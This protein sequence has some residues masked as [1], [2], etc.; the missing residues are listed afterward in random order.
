VDPAAWG[1]LPPTSPTAAFLP[2]NTDNFVLHLAGNG[3]DDFVPTRLQHVVAIH[4]ALS[5]PDFFSLMGSMD[6]V[7]PAFKDGGGC[8]LSFP[9]FRKKTGRSQ[10]MSSSFFWLP[11]ISPPLPRN[12]RLQPTGLLDCCYGYAV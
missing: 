11:L 8:E 4:K 10:K 2:A 1:Y 5:Y 3:K 6:L 7:L 12:L 9:H